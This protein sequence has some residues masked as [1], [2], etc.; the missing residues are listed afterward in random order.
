MGAARVSAALL[1]SASWL[2]VLRGLWFAPISPDPLMDLEAGGGFAANVEVYVPALGIT[3]AF[4][5]MLV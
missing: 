4:V 2:V 1:A 3:L 5:A